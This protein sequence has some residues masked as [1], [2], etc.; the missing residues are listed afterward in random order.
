M[1]QRHVGLQQQQQGQ[2]GLGRV[3]SHN[4]CNNEF[5]HLTFGY[6]LQIVESKRQIEIFRMKASEMST[7]SELKTEKNIHYNQ[8]D[9]QYM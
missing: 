1:F 4:V 5:L 6:I 8:F 3:L 2:V 9:L 7:M